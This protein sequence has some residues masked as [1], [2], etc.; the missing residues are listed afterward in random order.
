[1]HG[2]SANGNEVY[3]HDFFRSNLGGKGTIKND[4]WE[5][6]G[7]LKKYL[8]LTLLCASKGR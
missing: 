7:I 3:V 6:T 1:V 2:A 8:P 5:M 4:F